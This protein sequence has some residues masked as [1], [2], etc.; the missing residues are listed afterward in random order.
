MPEIDGYYKERGLSIL[1]KI[2]AIRD[3]KLQGGNSLNEEP[4]I[5]Q[6]IFSNFSLVIQYCFSQTLY[7]IRWQNF[8]TI[9][10][11]SDDEAS[12][13]ARRL[14]YFEQKIMSLVVPDPSYLQALSDADQVW[15][16]FEKHW[17]EFLDL[18]QH[19][20]FASMFSQPPNSDKFNKEVGMVRK[21]L[22][23]LYG[24]VGRVY[25]NIIFNIDLVRSISLSSLLCYCF[26]EEG[27]LEKK[28]RSVYVSHLLKI[29]L[30]MDD[31]F[32]EFNQLVETVRPYVAR[33]ESKAIVTRRHEN[34]QSF[35]YLVG[36]G[37]KRKSRA[38]KTRSQLMELRA[39]G[40]NNS[41]DEESVLIL[42]SGERGYGTTTL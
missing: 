25:E 33:V 28:V 5:R 3:E 35:I 15:E 12:E 10:A 20:F 8:K 34:R 22:G 21:R 39:P 14:G 41:D 19:F 38:D 16:L 11:L 18:E 31:L 23:S 37:N 17:G 42:E 24:F 4:A 29:K 40:E 7:Q 27:D 26:V 32:K 2:N 13:L 30:G 9:Y 1:A 36:I 6:S